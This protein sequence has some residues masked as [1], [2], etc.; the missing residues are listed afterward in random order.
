MHV[1]GLKLDMPGVDLLRMPLLL[2]P[3]LMLGLTGTWWGISPLT[4]VLG[5][6]APALLAAAFIQFILC[7]P[8]YLRAAAKLLRLKFGGDH[9]LIVGATAAFAL[10]V[11]RYQHLSPVGGAPQL[12]AIWRDASFGAALP[13]VAVIGDIVLRAA[14]RPAR[15]DHRAVPS[16]TV[17]VAAGDLIPGDGVVTEGYSEIQ[18]PL[19]KDD[20]YPVLVR[21]GDRVHLGARNGDGALRIVIDSDNR[22]DKVDLPPVTRDRLQRLLDRVALATLALILAVIAFRVGQNGSTDGMLIPGLRMLSLAA[23]LGLGLVFSAPSSEIIA[24]ARRIGLEIRDI[25]ALDRLRR[26]GGVAISHRGVLVPD[27][28]KMI[29]AHPVNDLAATD[30]IRRA[31]AVAQ[32]GHDP[33]G[34]AILDF[35]VGYRMR[36]KPAMTYHAE[37]GKGISAVTESQQLFLGTREYLE[38]LGF[39]CSPLNDAARQALQQGRRLRWMA[40]TQPERRVIGILV[41]GAPSVSGAVEA[42][43]NLDRL[44][45]ATAWF[46]NAEDPG[47]QGLAKHLKIKRLLPIDPQQEATALAEFREDVGPLLVVAADEVPWELKSGDIV[48]PFGHRLVERMGAAQIVTTRHDPRIVVDLFLLAARHRQ[49]VVMNMFI[50]Y[51]AALLLALAPFWLG[52]RSDLGSYEVAVVLLLALSPLSLRALSLTAN[53]VDE[54]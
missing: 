21:P 33:W 45:L 54:E 19:G 27:R 38:G 16:G 17:L 1:L 20:V 4:P 3:L 48:L 23:P 51:G 37:I 7:L 49:M 39:D 8:I 14:Y 11:W 26:V 35:A 25:A 31:A 43:K 24:A 9:L 5:F 28:L 34:K 6:V 46:A 12:L 50:A 42:V 41:F 40:E 29:S 22:A 47:H 18:D 53:E 10:A 2:L 13:S 36:L 52:P 32:I 44:G 30:L 15:K